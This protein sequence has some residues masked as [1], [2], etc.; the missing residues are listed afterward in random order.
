MFRS[1]DNEVGDVCS[2]DAGGDT[3]ILR[4]N[5]VI[6]F[7]K[8]LSFSERSKGWI[9]FKS[10]LPESALSINNN[11]YSFKDGDLYVHH[12]NSIRNNFYG[13][14]FD[15]SV[16]LL[17]NENPASV[18]S[19]AA[20]NYE[21]SQARINSNNT[22]GLY[23]NLNDKAG[24]YVEN[25]ITNLQ[26]CDNI[27]FKEKEGKWFGF[28]KGSS[29]S[30]ANLDESEFSVQGIGIAKT[31]VGEGNIP[32]VCLTIT[33][34]PV[35]GEIPGCMDPLATNYDPNANIQNS[36]EDCIYP[37][38]V[39]GCTDPGSDNYNAN[40]EIDDGSCFISGCM[41]SESVNY[42]PHATVS[43]DSC[44]DVPPPP[45]VVT[46]SYQSHVNPTELGPCVDGVCYGNGSITWLVEGTS[47][48]IIDTA[49]SAILPQSNTMFY[50]NAQ[51]TG[52][53]YAYTPGVHFPH[54]TLTYTFD[55]T[56][57]TT[58]ITWGGLGNHH[59]TYQLIAHTNKQDDGGYECYD[60]NSFTGL[61]YQAEP[62]FEI[63]GDPAQINSTLD[64]FPVWS[65]LNLG[66]V[67]PW[68]TGQ[69]GNAFDNS[70]VHVLARALS[71]NEQ[72][73]T[74]LQNDPQGASWPGTGLWDRDV[75]EIGLMG[76]MGQI[77]R[78][79]HFRLG[80]GSG[81][82]FCIRRRLAEAL[83]AYGLFTWKNDSIGQGASTYWGN[84]PATYMPDGSG[85]FPFGSNSDAIGNGGPNN[86]VNVDPS[87]TYALSNGP[88]LYT[89]TALLEA[90]NSLKDS[91]GVH[92]FNFTP[93][94]TTA[95]DVYEAME[96]FDHIGGTGHP[97][98]DAK[99]VIQTTI[100][101]CDNNN[102]NLSVPIE[103]TSVGCF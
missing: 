97:C 9:S 27:E 80:F 66:Q 44:E 67:N 61:A 20:I 71:R 7:K 50:F 93:G 99:R 36:P 88:A 100:H 65:L 76:S 94:V 34:N 89:W 102:G 78:V 12:D 79:K 23:S 58:T 59:D 29:T 42:N 84:S 16:T 37:P 10:F 82:T 90:L 103:G 35:C 8:T 13:E 40:A 98:S 14:Q 38:P 73:W 56:N 72:K 22:D 95:T 91:A 54:F 31:V 4:N 51:V 75:S 39:S 69:M 92:L 101:C 30:L 32:T 74:F 43:D 26:D 33:P 17:F 85:W 47:D 87:F 1:E 45:C 49:T 6:P 15:S 96:E 24:W 18:K 41:D 46:V 53:S 62:M 11:Y 55:T 2:C 25:I 83:E 48:A 86:L 52:A 70:G 28:I 19:F 3:E 64:Y 57:N 81:S 5:S 60:I 77:M 21:G 68:T 63:C